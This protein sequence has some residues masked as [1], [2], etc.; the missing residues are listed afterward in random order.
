MN[1]LAVDIG[2]THVKFRTQEHTEPVKV[3]S[4]KKMTPGKMMEAIKENTADWNYDR[5]SLG[6][7]GPVVHDKPLHDP[8]NLGEGWRHFD[9]K[10]AFDNKPIRILNDA[11][12]QALGSYEGGRML[13]LGLGTGLGSAMVVENVGAGHGDRAPAVE[14]RQDL[15]RA[16]WCEGAE[17]RRA[18][19]LD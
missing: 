10:T 12:T 17:P 3:K 16:G 13:F 8:A 2:G 7:P 11:A 5:V 6:Y 4:G 9:F 1:V 19:A 18:Q 14:E 15:R